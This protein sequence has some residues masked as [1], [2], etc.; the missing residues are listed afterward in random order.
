M[1]KGVIETTLNDLRWALGGWNASVRRW[2]S[3]GAGFYGHSFDYA[4]NA[5]V[6]IMM[7]RSILLMLFQVRPTPQTHRSTENGP[8]RASDRD[9]IRHGGHL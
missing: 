5:Q 8:R 4:V 1:G 3:C 7:R 2:G 9:R 6:A